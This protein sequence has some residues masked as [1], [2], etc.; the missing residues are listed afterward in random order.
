LRSQHRPDER[1]TS[2]RRLRSL[3]CAIFTI[4][5]KNCAPHPLQTGLWSLSY[6][7]TRRSW[8]FRLMAA[9]CLRR[10]AADGIAS[11]AHNDGQKRKASK[12]IARGGLIWWAFGFVRSRNPIQNRLTG[13]CMDGQ[14]WL[15]LSSQRALRLSSR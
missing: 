13:S 9:A 8:H 3:F 10:T 4:T 5:T 15:E 1:A 14:H 2:A 11:V 7:A 6:L 12:L